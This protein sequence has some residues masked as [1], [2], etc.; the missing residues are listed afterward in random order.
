MKLVELPF[1]TITEDD[2]FTNVNLNLGDGA[3]LAVQVKVIDNPLIG[4][5]GDAVNWTWA[6]AS[7]EKYSSVR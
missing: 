3:A 1:W 4:K 2:P 7:N 6:G 5:G